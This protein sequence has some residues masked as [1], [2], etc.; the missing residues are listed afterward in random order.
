MVWFWRLLNSFLLLVF[1]LDRHIHVGWRSR[2]TDVRTVLLLLLLLHHLLLGGGRALR[3]PYGVEVREGLRRD[4]EDAGGFLFHGG[5]NGRHRRVVHHAATDAGVAGLLFF[6]LRWFLN[7]AHSC[8]DHLL[9]FHLEVRAGDGH[10]LRA[11]LHFGRLRGTLLLLLWQGNDE[12]SH[13]FRLVRVALKVFLDDGVEQLHH[14]LLHFSTLFVLLPVLH[15]IGL[16]FV[17][18]ISLLC[19]L[20]WCINL[21]L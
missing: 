17:K 5:G 4:V 19:W 9:R 6:L 10:A 18:V 14:L 13:A 16:C 1:L 7:W 20:V 15:I 3:L 21:F 11:P 2:G 8:G 12:L